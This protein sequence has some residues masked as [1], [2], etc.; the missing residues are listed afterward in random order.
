MLKRLIV[1]AVILFLF[2]SGCFPS[3]GKDPVTAFV[4]VNLVPMTGNI[5]LPDQTVLVRGGRI[6]AV[7]LSN[8]IKVPRKSAV[9]DGKGKWLMP[10]L[11]DMHVHTKD[12]WTGPAWPVNPLE[13]Y[14]ANGVTTIRSLGP[15]GSDPE[16]VLRWRKEIREGSLPG[17]AIYT[18]GP[19]L[20]GPVPDPAGAVLVQ[21]KEGYDFIK[22]YSYVTRQE[23]DAVMAAAKKESIYTTGHIPF[24]VGLDGVLGEGMDEIAHIEELDFEFLDIN[25]DLQLNRVDI[26]KGIIAQAA[27]K[28]SGDLALDMQ[29]LE[30]KHG[31][32]IREIA[33]KL[34]GT[35]VPVCTTLVI[36]EGIVD[37]LSSPEKFLTRRENRFLPEAY[38]QTYRLGQEK[39]QFLFRGHEGL[40]PFKYRM[41][42]MLTKELKAAGVTL[43]LGTD[44]GTGGMG[45]VPGFSIHDELRILTEVG[46]TP[47]EAIRTGTVSAAKAIEKMTGKRDFG[48]V[49]EG[50]R[51]DFI[52]VRGNPLEDVGNIRQPLGVM[53][54]GRW[55]PEEKLKKMIVVD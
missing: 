45:I 48:T 16:H 25:P 15:L 44:S 7:G 18:S 52:L 26:F 39:H 3:A 38:L 43:L 6:E 29:A 27:E 21:K 30:E 49:E 20:Y 47:Y 41:E 2:T 34:K 17:P 8:E 13:L 28:F 23:F 4:G 19:I 35:E 24:L 51:A 50:K 40:A 10:G 53:A 55:Y 14:L 9:I 54:A 32:K 11:A 36:A 1:L 46:F 22:I 42:R 31:E 12:D 5:V 33:I 37:K